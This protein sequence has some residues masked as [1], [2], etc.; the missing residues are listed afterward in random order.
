MLSMDTQ[1]MEL[2]KKDTRKK[3]LILIGRFVVVSRRKGG[4]WLL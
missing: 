2:W 4:D 1:D 3:I